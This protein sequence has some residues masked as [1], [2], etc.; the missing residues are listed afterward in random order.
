MTLY[1]VCHDDPQADWWGMHGW[2]TLAVFSSKEKAQNFITEYT[3][4]YKELSEEEGYSY[5][6]GY[7]FVQEMELD[8][9]LKREGY[10]E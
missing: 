1:C 3:Q 2:P 7:L 4:R 6:T 8:G 5:L 9:E 10:D